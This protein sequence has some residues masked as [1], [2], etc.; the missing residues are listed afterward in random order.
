[1]KQS[2]FNLVSR[3]GFLLTGFLIP[4]LASGLIADDRTDAIIQ[5]ARAFVGSE[6]ALNR[7]T[8][9]H[10]TGRLQSEEG[11]TG[12]VDIIFQKPYFQSIVV[13]VENVR[14]TTALSGYD[15][16][17]KIEDVTNE[18]DWELTLLEA[19]QIRRLQANTLENLSFYRPGEKDPVQ[20]ID[21]GEVEVDGITCDKLVFRHS[22]S[23]QFIRYFDAASGRLVLT[24]TEQG[25]S[26]RELGEILVD[27]VRFPER[28]ITRVGDQSSTIIFESVEVNTV[29]DEDRFDV[30]MLMPK[31][32]S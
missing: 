6:E 20:V 3:S 31:S 9:I 26:I 8:S 14:E 32:S 24:E 16:W 18:S 23:I 2:L 17:R 1:M 10:Y 12:R 29:F 22:A 21:D 19:P 4:T 5:R 28:V 27:G 7:I 13:E 15:G 30:P 11:T 25:G